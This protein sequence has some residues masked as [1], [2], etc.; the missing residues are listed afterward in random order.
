MLHGWTNRLRYL[1]ISAP[2][3]SAASQPLRLSERDNAASPRYDVP[4]LATLY[5][6]A[7]QHSLLKR[8]REKLRPACLKSSSG[9]TSRQ[10]NPAFGGN[11][12]NLPAVRVNMRRFIRK[13]GNLGRLNYNIGGTWRNFS[14]RLRTFDR[15]ERISD[16]PCMGIGENAATEKCRHVRHRVECI[17]VFSE[18]RIGEV[19]LRLFAPPR[20]KQPREFVRANLHL[21]MG[22]R[23]DVDRLVNRRTPSF[24]PSFHRSFRSLPSRSIVLPATSPI[25]VIARRHF[26]VTEIIDEGF[27]HHPV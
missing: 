9:F 18:I 5:P 7:A 27:C 11:L 2:A 22:Y 6:S 24:L 21:T 20:A 15:F 1:A 14:S 16:S 13:Q 12:L 3:T 8:A 23:R 19:L 17:H 26:L 10:V 4:L 25:P